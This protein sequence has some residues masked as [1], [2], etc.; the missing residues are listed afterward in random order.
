MM[1]SASWI[2]FSESGWPHWKHSWDVS[3]VCFDYDL[4][5]TDFTD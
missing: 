4:K 3:F 5:Q 1:N 2:Q